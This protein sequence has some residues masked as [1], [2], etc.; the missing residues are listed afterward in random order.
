M[1]VKVAVLEDDVALREEILVPQ[2]DATGFD[3]EG[4]GSSAELYRRMTAV[5][6]EL[7][8]LD[9]KL[10]NENGLD[11]ARHLRATSPIGIVTL[12]GRGSQAERIRGLTE[13]VDAWLAK[14]VEIELLAAT[15]YSLARRMRL[16]ANGAGEAPV[17]AGWRLSSAGWRLHAPDDRNIPL[18]LLERRLLMRLFATPGDLVTHDELVADLASA[19]ENFDQHR[20]EMLIHRLRRKIERQLGESLPLRSVRGSG[21]VMLASDERQQRA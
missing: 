18:N 15:L 8:V 13:T 6:F 14:P 4:F 2:L 1:R 10:P 21:Y 3:V 19:V 9:L 17:S 12:T 5:P 16:G 7:L 20:L 11:V